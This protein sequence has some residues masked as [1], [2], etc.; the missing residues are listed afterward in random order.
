MRLL[1]RKL[2]HV[3]RL[4]RRDRLLHDLPR[5]DIKHLKRDQRAVADLRADRIGAL[6]LEIMRLAEILRDGARSALA[7]GEAERVRARR[8]EALDDAGRAALLLARRDAHAHDE[9][10]QADAVR[11]AH[12]LARREEARVARP[13]EVE[14]DVQE[15]AL[16][17][18]RPRADVDVDEHLP[19]RGA[20]GLEV[21]P[22][23][24]DAPADVLRLAVCE[25][26][27]HVERVLERGL[28]ADHDVESLWRSSVRWTMHS[29]EDMA[30]H[31]NSSQDHVVL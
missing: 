11:L 13:E 7:G 1:S 27:A 28:H 24:H 10:L 5:Q 6:Q 4:F 31:S 8:R 15:R 16:L 12:A 18:H 14:A 20:H 23:E 25:E 19:D 9:P 22:P 3:L 17:V 21:A 2:E 26:G 30:A 29:G